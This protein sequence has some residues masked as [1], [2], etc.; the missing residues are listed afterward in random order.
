MMVRIAQM[1]GAAEADDFLQVVAALRADEGRLLRALLARLGEEDDV[2][3]ARMLHGVLRSHP[4]LR[5]LIPS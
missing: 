4:M 5:D 1:D 2:R 3:E